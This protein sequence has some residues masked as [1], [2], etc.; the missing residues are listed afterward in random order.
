MAAQKSKPKAKGPAPEQAPAVAE[1]GLYQKWRPHT[2]DEV[3]GQ[4]NAV[5]ELRGMIQ[6][7]T[8]PRS[9]M[10]SGPSGV[11]KTT[12]AR[13]VGTELGCHRDDFFEIN[14]SDDRGI[15]TVRQ[16]SDRLSLRPRKGGTCRMWLLDEC[17]AMTPDAQGALMKHLEEAPKH[18]IFML[19]TTDPQKMREAIRTRCKS[20][21]L[22]PIG[23]KE[24]EK[25]L[26]R[27]CRGEQVDYVTPDVIEKIAVAADGCARRALN[28]LEGVFGLETEEQM[29]E[30]VQRGD[31]GNATRSLAQYLMNPQSTWAEVAAALR[32]LSNGEAEGVR[33]GILGYAQAILLS[34][35]PVPKMMARAASVL[36]VFRYDVYTSEKPGLTAMCWEL[37]NSK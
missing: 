33:R 14:C 26:E 37:L 36:M 27:V 1:T 28:I 16:I 31:V 12:L 15:N 24:L 5:R 19:A 6:A 20:I 11:G 2:F 13:I 7:P 17:Q 25:L 35:K 18:V 9:L 4:E 8:F 10:F 29:L 30:A 23:Y 32:P 21:D 34:E 3:V 22:R